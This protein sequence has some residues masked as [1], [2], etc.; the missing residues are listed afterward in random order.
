MATPRRILL[1]CM[2]WVGEERRAAAHKDKGEER[3]V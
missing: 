3:E 2:V 1:S